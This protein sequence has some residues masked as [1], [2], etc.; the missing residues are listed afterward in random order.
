MKLEPDFRGGWG[1]GANFTS[2][3]AVYFQWKGYN[4]GPQVDSQ[5]LQL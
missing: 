3:L 1:M 2:V 4:G 5:Q